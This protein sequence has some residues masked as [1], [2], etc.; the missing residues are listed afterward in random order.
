[1]KHNFKKL[2]YSFATINGEEFG[3]CCISENGCSL[4]HIHHG[5]MFGLGRMEQS[6]ANA[7]RIAACV[8]YCEEINT[9]EL[10]DKRLKGDL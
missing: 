10:E 5:P 6:R 3:D 1:M 4:G 2:D 9:E 7:R 8:N